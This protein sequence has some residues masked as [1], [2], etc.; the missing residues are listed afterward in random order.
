M[1]LFRITVTIHTPSLFDR[2]KTLTLSEVIQAQ[3]LE[4]ALKDA[5]D[6]AKKFTEDDMAAMVSNIERMS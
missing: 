3:N 6:K 5:Q 1:A 4:A 2:T